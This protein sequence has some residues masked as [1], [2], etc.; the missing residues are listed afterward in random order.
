MVEVASLVIFLTVIA[1]GMVFAG[2]AKNQ[3][4]MFWNGLMLVVALAGGFLLSVRVIMAG[5]V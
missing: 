3:N 1:V 4:A 2:V 5:G